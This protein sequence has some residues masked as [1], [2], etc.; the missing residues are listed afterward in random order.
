MSRD[1]RLLWIGETTSE[2]GS[3]I[4]GVAFPL[5]A[6]ATLHADAF[7]V[8]LLASAAWMPWLLLGLPAGAWVDRVRRKR[9]MLV[10]DLAAAACYVSIPVAWW[11]GLLTTVQLIVVAVLGGTATVFFTTAY[12]AYLPTLVP[13]SELTS[14]NARLQAG[15]SSA[16][17][18]G[19]GASGLIAQFLGLVTGL[20][21]DAAS[22]LV[23]AM[24]LLSIRAREAELPRPTSRE[25]LRAQIIEGVRFVAG[26]RILH[27]FVAYG[28]VVNLGLMGYQAIQPVFLL[29]DVGVGPGAIGGMLMAGSVGGL[30]GALL[31]SRIARRFGTARAVL[32]CQLCAVPFGLLLP[33]AGP[34]LGLAPFAIGQFVQVA[35]IVA[36]NVIFAGFLQGYCPAE[37]RGRVSASSAVVNYG[38]VALGALLGGILADAIGTRPT[39]WAM[40]VLLT[41]SLGIL[42][43]SPIR[44]LRDFPAQ[45]SAS[46]S[47]P[48]S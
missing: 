27:S 32:W 29:R 48:R 15:R 33:L 14:A 16:E 12:H 6:A 24:C 9:I 46:Y 19:P 36:S 7:V 3:N 22:F 11:L 20:L 26:D 30:I 2:F 38:T 35:G 28:A 37:L 39:M 5:I 45:P 23:S 43:A 1:F 25:S 10:C 42:I 34:G 17:A 13:K 8:G 4:T 44:K 31:A 21:F 47:Q 40:T 41:L 18:L